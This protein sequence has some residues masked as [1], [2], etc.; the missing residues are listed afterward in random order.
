V[1][2]CWLLKKKVALCYVIAPVFVKRSAGI[3]N[4]RVYVL[5][6]ARENVCCR[7]IPLLMILTPC[8]DGGG[9]KKRQLIVQDKQEANNKVGNMTVLS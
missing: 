5:L 2:D 3:R 6:E 9:V 7:F 4:Y 8:H 1:N